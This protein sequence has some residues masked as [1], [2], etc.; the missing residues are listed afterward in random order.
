MPFHRDQEVGNAT[1][2][3]ACVTHDLEQHGSSDDPIPAGR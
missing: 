1:P 2:S 3:R